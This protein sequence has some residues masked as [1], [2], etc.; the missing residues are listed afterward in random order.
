LSDLA[1]LRRKE[2]VRH[3]ED[4][5]WQLIVGWEPSVEQRR[6]II[7]RHMGADFEARA[8]AAFVADA[9]KGKTK[10]SRRGGK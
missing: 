1:L 4:G 10:K 5:T 2:G 9:P 8:V 6:A 3:F 7:A